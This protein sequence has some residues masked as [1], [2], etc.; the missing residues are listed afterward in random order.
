MTL[1]PMY[2]AQWEW[3]MATRD[4]RLVVAEQIRQARVLWSAS[5]ARQP[6]E[7]SWFAKAA[8]M[9][10][11]KKLRTFCRNLPSGFPSTAPAEV[12]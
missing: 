1:M 4:Q 11:F 9:S 7:R 3:K 5:K 12:E 2:T 10:A 6:N 8:G